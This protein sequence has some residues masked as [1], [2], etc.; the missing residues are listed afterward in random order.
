MSSPDQIYTVVK[1]GGVPLAEL[2]DA[3]YAT[4]KAFAEAAR[5]SVSDASRFCNGKRTPPEHV[6]PQICAALGVELPQLRVPKDTLNKAAQRMIRSLESA[7]DLERQRAQ[8][9]EQRLAESAH[10]VRDL[11][12]RLA[13]I[14]ELSA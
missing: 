10:E 7:L 14:R 5:I 11:R 1:R 4:R 8:R 3:N 2:V 9:L 6:V 13:K 12:T